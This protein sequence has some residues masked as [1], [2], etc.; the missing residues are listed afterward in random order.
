MRGLMK[1]AALL[2]LLSGCRSKPPPP[3]LKVADL[4]FP[5]VVIFGKASVVKFASAEALGTM[6]IGSLNA[7]IG[8]PPLIDSTFTVYTLTKLGSTHNGLWLMANPTGVTPVTFELERAPKSGLEAARELMRLR[9][10][11]QTWRTDLDEK[12]RALAAEQT[13][14]GMFAIV[15]GE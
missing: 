1:W 2:A 14:A 7:V 8:P 4:H 10:E 13:L 6:S 15:N 11:E 3:P 5:V 9:L 12:R